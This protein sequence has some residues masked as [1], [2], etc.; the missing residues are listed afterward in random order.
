MKTEDTAQSP[1]AATQTPTP[2]PAPYTPTQWTNP[3]SDRSGSPTTSSTSNDAAIPHYQAYA[4]HYPQGAYP[5]HFQ[6][7][8]PPPPQL[9]RPQ[10]AVPT[11]T[12]TASNSGIDT[13]DIATLND[14]LGSAGVDLRAE[15][16]TLQRT[17]SP[18]QSYRHHEDRTRKQAPTPSF[19]TRFISP[20]VRAIATTHKLTKPIP[21][22]SVTYIALALRA[23]L[24]SLITAMISAAHH[25]TDTQFDRP[26]S[27]YTDEGEGTPMWSIVIRSDVAKQ[28]AALERVER[29]EE[30]RLR[31]ERKERLELAAAHTAALAAQANGAHAGGMAG[32]GF[33]DL[34]GGGKKKKKK[35]GP[36]VTARN[37][38]EDVRKKMSNAVATQAAGLGGKY[39][40]MNAANASTPKPKPAPATPAA[41]PAPPAQGAGSAPSPTATAPAATSNPAT[42]AGTWARPYVPTKK[43]STTAQAQQSPEDDSRTLV[44]MRDAMFVVEK[45]RGHGA[46]RGAARGWV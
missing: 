42:P 38:S 13:A 8:A 3:H 7:Y 33:D 22:D 30:T 5:T 35:D 25:R 10:P 43:N 20:T 12:V 37:M 2:T 6:T 40:W 39:A 27:M 32:D 26:A 46:G 36:G 34:D 18:H 15:E 14:A 41:T 24:Q 11:T 16:E 1:Q 17:H 4:S 9:Q 23:R 44:T 28:L 19:D 31:R 21:D 45:E 29:E